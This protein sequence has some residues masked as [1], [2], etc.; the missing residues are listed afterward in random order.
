MIRITFF[1]GQFLDD[2]NGT[3]P[4]GAGPPAPA[5]FPVETTKSS[6]KA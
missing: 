2:L 3:G 4:A 6:I 5:G 1:S